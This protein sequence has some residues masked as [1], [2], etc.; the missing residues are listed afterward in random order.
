MEPGG[1]P[2][3]SRVTD[4]VYYRA[5]NAVVTRCPGVPT[6]GGKPI[7]VTNGRSYDYPVTWSADSK[8][9]YSQ[10][11][12]HRHH[13]VEARTVRVRDRRHREPIPADGR[14]RHHSCGTSWR[15]DT[16]RPTAAT[17]GSRR[18]RG[19]RPSPSWPMTRRPGQAH[20]G[21]AYRDG[22]SPRDPE[23]STSVRGC[24]TS[25]SAERRPYELRSVRGSQPSRA[26]HNFS[27]LGAPWSVAVNKRSSGVRRAR[28]RLD[29]RVHGAHDGRGA[30]VDC[31]P[32]RV[33]DLSWS[34]DGRALAAIVPSSRDQQWLRRRAV[35]A[36]DRRRTR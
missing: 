33:F 27:P 29:R 10:D 6:A 22:R 18:R 30:A 12:R 1:S 20:A 36:C 35:R 34:P 24:T 11:R 32:W 15:P 5:S 17:G 4:G 19:D 21:D 3:T 9:L 16:F 13:E 31:R 26:L 28:R 14:H 7:D 8:R 25:S 2:P 23:D